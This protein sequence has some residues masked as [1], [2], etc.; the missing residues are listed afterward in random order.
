MER[1]PLEKWEEKY[2]S[3]RTVEEKREAILEYIRYFVEQDKVLE[4]AGERTVS[5]YGYFATWMLRRQICR[6]M[7]WGE[8]KSYHGWTREI[9]VIDF[10]LDDS[11]VTETLK[12]METAGYIKLSKSG[13]GYKVLK[14]K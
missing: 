10:D 5:N 8:E 3:L 12:R 1:M 7:K 4:A 6:V 14:T 11:R 13:G 2:G 9:N